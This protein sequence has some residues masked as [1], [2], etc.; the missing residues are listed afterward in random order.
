MRTIFKRIGKILDFLSKN[1]NRLKTIGMILLIVSFLLSLGGGSCQRNKAI[2]LAG[3]ITGLNLKN[4]ILK[5]NIAEKDQELVINKIERDSLKAVIKG[6]NENTKVL[7][8][9]EIAVRSDLRAIKDSLMNVPA[10]S[11]YK[12]LQTQ[13]YPYPGELKYPFNEIQ[14]RNIHLDYLENKGL[15]TLNENLTNQIN[16]CK[17]TLHVKDEI[18]IKYGSDVINLLSQKGDHEEIIDNK[19][20]EIELLT[21]QTDT[22]RKKKGFWKVVSGILAGLAILIAL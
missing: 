8:D 18:M 10:D 2:E 16:I 20:E 4:I 22:E 9:N 21:E 6:L 12:F 3:K 7:E 17:E 1:I 11:S 15:I 13:A 14:T 19:N 5:E